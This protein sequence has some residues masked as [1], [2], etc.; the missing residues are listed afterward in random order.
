[1]LHHIKPKQGDPKLARPKQ[2]IAFPEI[3]EA[4]HVCWAQANLYTRKR[5]RANT[6]L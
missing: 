4:I 2:G 1:M 6:Q 5:F 3:V